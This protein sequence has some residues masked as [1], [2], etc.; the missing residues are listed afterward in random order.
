MKILFVSAYSEVLKTFIPIINHFTNN[1]ICIIAKYIPFGADYEKS[2]NIINKNK[3]DAYFIENEEYAIKKPKNVFDK[4]RKMKIIRHS[5][6]DYYKKIKPDVIILGP[7]KN[8]LERFI[9]K[10]AKKDFIPSI[11]FQ[12]SLGPITKRTF[13][14]TK[15]KK[16]IN[17]I[18]NH[19]ISFFET[20]LRISSSK[21]LLLTHKILGFYTQ[22]YAPCYGGGDATFLAVIG[23][24][25]KSFF[26]SIRF[27][28]EKIII[29]GHPLLEENYYFKKNTSNN[30]FQLLR[31]PDDSN[32]IL[33]CTGR[34][35]DTTDNYLS[36]KSILE[37]RKDKL[38]SILKSEYTGF[39]V[40]KLHPLENIDIFKELENLSS[41]VRVIQ[42]VDVVDLINYCE[43]LF[44]RYSTSAYYGMMY[45]KPV[46]TH[47]YPPV[48]FGSYFEEIGGTIHVNDNLDLVNYLDL[49]IN[50]DKKTH[51]R[52]KKN[53]VVFLQKHLNIEQQ[54]NNK[55]EVLPSLKEFEKLI[56]KI[57]LVK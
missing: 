37:W 7:D 1:E 38:L 57:S 48:P 2:K 43:I 17:E 12:W 13:H 54:I 42:D 24:S 36:K 51:A 53:Q 30:I 44:T 20:I 55:I 27:N 18:Q 33:F 45:S 31:F 11:C 34:Y 47:N 40:V 5:A 41:R 25:S 22:D 3:L 21:L 28:N 19:K 15:Q 4:F 14:E 35:L 52:I 26:N 16:L 23:Q 49:I 46:I 39:I 50:S 6:Y 29:T 56:R 10:R 9:I 8:N 32:F